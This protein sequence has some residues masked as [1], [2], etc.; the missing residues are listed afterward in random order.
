MK[1]IR[2]TLLAAV[3]ALSLSAGTTSY[4]GSF[5]PMDANALF[6]WEFTTAGGMFNAQSYGF[7]GSANAPGGT[8][9]AGQ[10]I[11]V[12]G[13]DTYL[14]LFTGHG[15]TATFLASNDDGLCPPGFAA[16]TCGDSTLDILLGPGNYTLVLSVFSNFSLAENLGMGNLGDGFIGLGNYFSTATGETQTPEWAIDITFDPVTN[17]VPKPGTLASAALAAAAAFALRRRS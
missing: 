6:V 15:A 9:F 8:N 11:P 17:P 7:G 4:G 2:L 16:P 14:S 5:D 3:A 12:G 1:Q 13:F 10:M